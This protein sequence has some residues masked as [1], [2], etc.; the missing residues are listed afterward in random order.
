M[1]LYLIKAN[2]A[3]AKNAEARM[4]HFSREVF[5][6]AEEAQAFVETFK[7]RVTTPLDA[8]DV[9]YLDPSNTKIT[10]VELVLSGVLKSE[11]IGT[12]A[13]ELSVIISAVVAALLKLSFSAAVAA[14]L[15]LYSLR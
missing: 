9:G 8:K 4:N 2:G 15:K 7:V 11:D 3:L 5:L 1:K 6:T 10:V 12:V 13:E 14:L